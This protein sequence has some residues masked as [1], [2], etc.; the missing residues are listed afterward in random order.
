MDKRGKAYLSRAKQWKE[1]MKM[2]REIIIDCDVEEDFKWMHPCYTN[3]GKNIVPGS[4]KHPKFRG[5]N[6]VAPQK[7]VIVPLSAVIESI[8]K[9]FEQKG[10]EEEKNC[11]CSPTEDYDG[12]DEEE[13]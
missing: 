3:K 9:D 13:H 10:V 12:G 11:N 8:Q 7:Q 4:A 2:L 1:E 5:K 6:K